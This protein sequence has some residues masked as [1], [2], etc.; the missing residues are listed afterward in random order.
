MVR[1]TQDP[2]IDRK[3]AVVLPIMAFE[4]THFQYDSDRKLNTNNKIVR[5]TDDPDTLKFNYNPVPYNLAFSLYIYVKNAEDGTKIF[6]QILPMFKPDFTV[7]AHLIPEMDIAMDIPT[8]LDNMTI[9][10]VYE[11]DF[12]QRKALIY[13]LDFTMK[14]YYYGPLREKPI[15]K[16]VKSQYYASTDSNTIVRTTTVKPGLTADG[17][18]AYTEADSIDAHEIWVD[19]DYGWIETSEDFP[20]SNT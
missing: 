13:I 11:G 7:T 4:L 8:V 16:F 5:K 12:V 3:A 18:P 20:Q 14:G 10:D 9:Q 15:I 19:D 2:T 1:I 6:E 17:D